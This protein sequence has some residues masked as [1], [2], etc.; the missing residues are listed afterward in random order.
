MATSQAELSIPDV[1][2]RT[3]RSLRELSWLRFRRHKLAIAGAAILL[4]LV[5][6]A[7]FAPWISPIGPYKTNYRQI[8]K[9][10]SAEHILGTD[11]AGRD[12]FAR[13]L[14]GGRVTLSI[15]LVAV[16]ISITIGIVLGAISGFYGGM[17]DDLLSRFAEATMSFPRLIIIMTMV[18]VVGPSFY[19]VMMVIGLLG[20]PGTYRLVR[21]QFFSLRERDYVLAARVCGASDRRIIFRHC[22]PNTASSVIVAATFGVAGAMLIESSLGYLGMG[23]QP[24]TP[25]WG[26]MLNAAHGLAYLGTMPWLWMPPVVLISISVISINL[27]GDA[28]RDALDPRIG[29]R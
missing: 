19:N 22:L 28:L 27:L 18:S 2:V 10:P 14:Y 24:P 7:V 17:L 6:G 12:V 16:A 13:L 29:T 1:P 4:T 9:A 11:E 23:V 20:W 21:G 25:S 15:G 3:Q 8:R 5:L 26:N